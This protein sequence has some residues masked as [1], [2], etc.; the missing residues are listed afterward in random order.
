MV[1]FNE[2]GKLT[3]YRSMI[4]IMEEFYTIRL[5]YYDL[6]KEYLLSILKRDLEILSNKA[7]FIL[8]VVDNKLEIRKRK[9]VDIVQDL[10]KMQFTPMST[11]KQ[12]VKQAKSN[13][14]K[15][16]GGDELDEI[17]ENDEENS[18]NEDADDENPFISNNT[19][20]T[21]KD[22]NYLL[23][24]PLW[25]LTYERVLVIQEDKEK[26]EEELNELGNTDPRTLWLKDLNNLST[27]LKE[28]EIEEEND[29]IETNKLKELAKKEGGKKRKN[30][31]NA[32]T[33]K[34]GEK[35]KKKDSTGVENKKQ[36]KIN[37]NANPIKENKE[38]Q[39]KDKKK[40]DT[41]KEE[42]KKEEIKIKPIVTNN[43][44][45]NVTVNPLVPA[46]PIKL[47]E[48]QINSLPL[49]ERIKYRQSKFKYNFKWMVHYILIR[50]QIYPCL[51][52][53]QKEKLMMMLIT[54]VFGIMIYNLNYIYF[55]Y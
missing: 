10:I 34:E 38:K 16:I 22:Y 55:T 11:I 13:K 6:R 37:I 14:N 33:E 36:N 8:A 18:E 17:I 25:S 9:K 24:M 48:D 31:N 51:M 12:M 54:T 41:K 20:I 26:K 5:K 15:K 39:E 50:M 21:S 43:P 49:A 19:Q 35:K 32:N 3:R 7:R 53:F 28:I 30:N 42:V 27:V 4:D 47:T 45:Q 23:E 52:K 40:D 2:E 1:L 46:K 29:R 44:K